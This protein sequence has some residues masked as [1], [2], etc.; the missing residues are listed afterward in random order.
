M[1]R[2]TYPIKQEDFGLLED[3]IFIIKR[4]LLEKQ[5]E[6]AKRIESVSSLLIQN[7]FNN[8]IEL[9]YYN[10]NDN[11]FI[12]IYKDFEE[13]FKKF[14]FG[15]NLE[16]VNN[17]LIRNIEHFRD[18]KLNYAYATLYNRMI[19][20]VSY[21]VQEIERSFIQNDNSNIINVLQ[22]IRSDAEAENKL[23]MG[24]V[25]AYNNDIR[26]GRY[27]SNERTMYVNDLY[28]LLMPNMED[29][30]QQQSTVRRIEL[31]QNKKEEI[32]YNDLD[33]DD[34]C[35]NNEESKIEHISSN[36]LRRIPSI[37]DDL[38]LYEDHEHQSTSDTFNSNDSIEEH[39]ESNNAINQLNSTNKEDI[40]F[41]EFSININIIYPQDGYEDFKCKIHFDFTH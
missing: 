12:V 6:I 9:I 5:T 14:T 30:Q 33:S 29:N 7:G 39:V 3:E 24:I 16:R 10:P 35:E 4:K 37:I 13:K 15:D 20:S 2:K 22:N 34:D 26:F 28:R 11:K 19:E 1:E 8:Y 21:Y 31:A 25:E 18:E 41:T 23:L 17:V 27:V 36:G 32:S 40:K 38:S